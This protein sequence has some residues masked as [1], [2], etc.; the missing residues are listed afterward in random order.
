VSLLRP[1]S[2]TLIAL[3]CAANARAADRPNIIVILSDDMGYSDIGCYG[4]E[5]NTPTLN[6]LAENGLRFTQ[7]YNTGRCCP[8]RA[9]LLSGLYP[10]QAGIG[11]MMTDRGHDGYRG[12][13]NR[14][15]RTIAEMVRPAGYATYGVGKWHVTKHVDP[16]GPK[17]NWPL[18]RGFDR[19][20]GTIT[21]AGSFFDPGTLT[22]DNQNISPFTDPEYQPDQYY[23]T[24][25]ISDHAVRFI[26][27][28]L[29]TEGHDKPFFMY[30]AYT[31]AHW[32]M[33]AL[34]RDIS[35][36]SGKYNAGYKAIRDQRAERVVELGLVDK[37]A[38][39][40]PLVGDWEENA[41]KEWE[42]RCMEVYAA[43]IDSMDQGIGRIVT[44]LKERNEFENTLILFMQDNGG[45]QEGNGRRGDWKRP[46]AASLPVISPDAIRLDVVPK[47]NRA[48]VPTLTGPGVM[49]GPEDT[50][51]AYGINWANVSNTPFREYKHFVHEGGVSTPLIAH[52]PSGIKRQGDLE[53]QPGHLIDIAA[54]VVDLAQADYPEQIGENSIKPLEGVSLVPA[55]D[56]KS[57]DRSQPIFWEHEGNRAIRDGQWKLVAKENEPWELYDMVTDR[58][59]MHDLASK[60]PDLVKELSA[61]WDQWA[62]RANV[63]PLG[64]WR[65]QPQPEKKASFNRKQRT[66][67]LQPGDQLSQYDG[68]FV[69]KRGF[70]ITVEVAKGAD[71]GVLVAQGGSSE[72]YSLYLTD[73]HL[74]FA[75]R[76]GGKLTVVKSNSRL[77]ATASVV[78]VSLAQDGEVRMTVDGTLVASGQTPGAL[79]RQPLDG[80]TVGAD[81]TGLVGKYSRDNAFG[82][83]ITSV[84]IEIRA[85]GKPE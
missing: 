31:A 49:P 81:D 59:E 48:G 78:T 55:F 39:V 22:R 35:K 9:S 77:P 46:V 73:G 27:E 1:L 40:T 25:A 20:Y 70:Q 80:L 12:D 23:Y 60:R 44:S 66:F 51:I 8:T 13:L 74:Q 43:M 14:Q 76:H 53:R 26:N 75:T 11:W 54:T 82:G 58:T 3:L 71:T 72:G 85:P 37:N 62:A 57:L 4:G 42:A 69:E 63:L 15:C 45:C 41:N 6:G 83:T 29:K 50:Y 52:W 21:G 5:I 34:E 64:T 16:G 36:Y 28:H 47:Q 61:R 84:R 33:H 38:D 30:V 18:Q 65:V 17:H 10:H 24:D 79:T 7:F 68:P 32:P 67:D 19:F 56:G 2:V